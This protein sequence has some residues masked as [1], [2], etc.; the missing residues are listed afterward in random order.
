[1]DK[2]LKEAQAG[3]SAGVQD[4]KREEIFD[5]L[6][7]GHK[8]RS[9]FSRA[10]FQT[11]E[12]IQENLS[13]AFEKAKAAYE[14]E[15]KIREEKKAKIELVKKQ[16]VELGLSPQDV[17]G[18]IPAP[19]AQRMFQ[20]DQDKADKPVHIYKYRCYIFGQVYWASGI[21]AVTTPFKCAIADGQGQ[22]M[23]DF[24]VDEDEWLRTKTLTRSLIPE[25]C[26]GE[27]KALLNKYKQIKPKRNYSKA[28]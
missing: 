21:G 3:I 15:K 7:N 16:M 11:L 14:E 22:S 4:A 17:F 19:S 20:A 6:T 8:A 18:E 2:V 10:T 28:A 9:L 25:D 12:I 5:T 24:L 27:A 23:K 13:K 26:K 1:M